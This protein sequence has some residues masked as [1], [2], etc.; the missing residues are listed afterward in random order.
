[1]AFFGELYLRSTLPLL[2]ESVT[3]REVTYLARAFESHAPEGPL[4]DL[5][6]GHGRHAALLTRRLNR[7]VVGLELD[8][9]S[10]RQRRPG[11]PAVRGDLLA[12][13][14]KS[15]CLAGAYSWYSTLFG[16]EDHLQ[17]RLFEETARVLRPGG[18]FVLQTVPRGYRETHPDASFEGR[19]PSGDFLRE[20]S[21]FDAT[22][23]RDEGERVLTTADGRTLAA[24]YFVRSYRT[25][26]LLYLLE[27]AGFRVRFVH[28]GLDGEPVSAESV[29]LIIGAE[30]SNG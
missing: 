10:L 3:A 18:L 25:D 1:M 28:G 16:F 11:F 30:R 17:G 26:E 21:H 20:T 22:S 12:L 6:C 4:G 19:L 9:L 14:L 29:D 7:T 27:A 5:G 15:G 2:S 23:G 24:R 13:P 8:A